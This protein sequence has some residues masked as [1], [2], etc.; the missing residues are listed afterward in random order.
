MNDS[1][2]FNQIDI[3]FKINSYI[4]TALT[5]TGLILN[6]MSLIVFTYAKGKQPQIGGIKYLSILTLF[7]I[8]FLFFHWY[9]NILPYFTDLNQT[10]NIIETNVY[11]CKLIN[12]LRNVCRAVFALSTLS[13]SLERALAIFIPFY[14]IEHKNRVSAFLIVFIFTVSFTSP[15]HFAF[16]YD[17]IE[18][19][20]TT[21]NVCSPNNQANFEILTF[22]F[23]VFAIY[24]P[25][26]LVILINFSIIVKLKNYRVEITSDGNKFNNDILK[27]VN[28]LYEENFVIN[29]TKRFFNS[30]FITTAIFNNYTNAT[31]RNLKLFTANTSELHTIANRIKQQREKF[32]INQKFTN[33]NT[34]I[35]VSSVY[36][37]LNIPNIINLF[38]IFN[39]YLDYEL[40][41]RIKMNSDPRL[42]T[43]MLVSGIFNVTNY[44]INGVLFFIFGK[45]FRVHLYNIWKCFFKKYPCLKRTK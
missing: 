11:A 12:Y 40:D 17:L 1:E 43:Y 13:Y 22:F 31:G 38:F 39:P 8:I 26:F 18:S 15:I 19:N 6:S 44:S 25:L 32:T 7:S 45:V 30:E 23:N 33:T 37:L 41:A 5:I 28:K 21:A 3:S 4:V 36:I 14:I 24:L 2:N 34:L 42:V 10:L 29:K 20:S 9:I 35:L 27:M 16:D